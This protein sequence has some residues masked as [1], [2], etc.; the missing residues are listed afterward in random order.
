MPKRRKH[1]LYLKP[2]MKASSK[3]N[4]SGRVG[5]VGI[6]NLNWGSAVPNLDPHISSNHPRADGR[7]VG[8]KLE[9]LQCKLSEGMCFPIY[10]PINFPHYIPMTSSLYPC[11]IRTVDQ[12]DTSRR[13]CLRTSDWDVSNYCA[14][15]ETAVNAA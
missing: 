6:V 15:A 5:R 2:K 12:T 7:P 9:N 10:F 14:S 11:K 1:Q 8:N 4:A 3:T 13:T